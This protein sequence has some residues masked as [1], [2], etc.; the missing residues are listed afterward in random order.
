MTDHNFCFWKLELG[1]DER[2]RLWTTTLLQQIFHVFFGQLT[3]LWGSHTFVFREGLWPREAC[4]SVWQ[5]PNGSAEVKTYRRC[6]PRST[7][8]LQRIMTWPLIRAWDWFDSEGLCFGDKGPDIYRMQQWKED[9]RESRAF[10]SSDVLRRVF[11]DE[12]EFL[13][14]KGAQV[15]RM[16]HSIRWNLTELLERVI[17]GN[18]YRSPCCAGLS[19]PRVAFLISTL[20]WHGAVVAH[21]RQWLYISVKEVVL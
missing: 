5:A 4:L 11:S 7:K 19:V 2:L 14:W 9:R 12:F 3:Y 6:A 13:D 8:G 15:K 18:A 17:S 21:D 10:P 20:T 1:S 16:A